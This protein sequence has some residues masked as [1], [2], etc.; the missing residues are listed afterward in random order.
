[1]FVLEVKRPVRCK[2]A[3]E[4]LL[5]GL[6][7]LYTYDACRGSCD[8]LCFDMRLIFDALLQLRQRTMAVPHGGRGWMSRGL[9]EQPSID[10]QQAYYPLRSQ[11]LP[12]CRITTMSALPWHLKSR[13]VR[14]CR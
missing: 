7:W 4:Y 1:M 14:T 9:L 11:I 8:G 5:A 10:R 12:P 2:N 3:F 6:V 13:Y